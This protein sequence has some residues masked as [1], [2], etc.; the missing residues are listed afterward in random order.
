MATEA[1]LIDYMS[2]MNSKSENRD[3]K[4]TRIVIKDPRK[5]SHEVEEEKKED[6][7]ERALLDKIDNLRK[8]RGL[9]CEKISRNNSDP[10]QVKSSI[11]VG[12]S[13]K[14]ELEKYEKRKSTCAGVQ[15]SSDEENRKRK[16]KKLACLQESLQEDSSKTDEKTIGITCC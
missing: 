9:P 2:N 11:R 1:I 4:L 8:A 15:E 3:N 7:A 16:K 12:R 14:C 13:K 10:R 6:A 5:P